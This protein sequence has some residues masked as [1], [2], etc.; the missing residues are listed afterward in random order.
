MA[1]SCRVLQCESVAWPLR[2]NLSSLLARRALVLERAI[3][4]EE[5]WAA[6]APGNTGDADVLSCPV[7]IL[8]NIIFIN[9]L[10]F[11][12]IS[13]FHPT[14]WV[15]GSRESGTWRVR[16]ALAQDIISLDPS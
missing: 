12:N 13:F 4:E 10:H 15:Q 2:L 11:A 8:A 1:C 9:T 14:E 6:Q 3:L 16:E 5:G 7:W